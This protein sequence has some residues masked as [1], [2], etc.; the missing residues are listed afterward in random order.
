MRRPP[1]ARKIPD[2]LVRVFPFVGWFIYD[3]WQLTVFSIGLL[4]VPFIRYIPRLK[5]M[6]KKAGDWGHVFRRS[7][8]EDRF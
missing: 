2:A 4:L 8:L 1:K 6:R 5:E 3:R 7:G